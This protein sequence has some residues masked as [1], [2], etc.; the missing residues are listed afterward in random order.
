MGPCEKRSRFREQEGTA[1]VI[2]LLIVTTLVGLAVA[3]SEDS[4]VELSLAGFSR[5]G[6]RANQMALAGVSMARA[7]IEY[8]KDQG[9]DTLR[10]DWSQFSRES[11]PEDFLQ[12][13]SFSGRIIDEN[14]KMNINI[15][16][17]DGK[18]DETKQKRLERLFGVL[19]VN[20]SLVN[21]ILDWLDSDGDKRLEGAEDLYYQSLPNPY[22][23]GNGRLISLGQIFLIKDLAKLSQFGENG[24]MQLLDYVTIYGN[25]RI[26]INTAS[27]EVLQ[28]LD[29]GIDASIAE[30]IIKYRADKDFKQISD[31]KNVIDA[32]LYTK[33]SPVLTVASSAFFLEMRGQFQEASSRIRAVILREPEGSK[34]VY[35]QVS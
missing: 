22:A 18:I 30:D 32:D 2:T 27:A 24:Q 6:F 1:L 16:L 13:A 33:I 8:D 14:S 19:G 25:G 31:L 20:E 4:G 9:T 12:D 26:N 29:E 23:C 3:F 28:S 35:W 15:I 34:L 5:D 21:P 11:F 10:E 17:S 7:L